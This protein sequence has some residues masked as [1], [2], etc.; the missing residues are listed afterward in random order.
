[1]CINISL[2]PD[3]AQGL[4]DWLGYRYTFMM[5]LTQGRKLFL[6]AAHSRELFMASMLMPGGS[7]P[8]NPICSPFPRSTASER[9]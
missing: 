9:I 3:L 2:N 1:M 7:M 8:L 5:R 4:H 6:V